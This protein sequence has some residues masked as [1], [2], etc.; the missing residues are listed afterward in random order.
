MVDLLE[1]R[2]R[3]ARI[4]FHVVERSAIPG[5]AARAIPDEGLILIT[6]EA[7]YGLHDEDPRHELLIPHELAHFALRHAASFSRATTKMPHSMFE[8]SEIQAD[9]FS[10]EFVM[11]AAIVQ[12]H[13]QCAED[14]QKVFNILAKDAEIRRQVLCAEGLIQW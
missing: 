8:D 4:H 3:K 11:P 10:H 13:C 14:I 1:N 9:Q 5:E 7:Y 2:L 6:R 12:R